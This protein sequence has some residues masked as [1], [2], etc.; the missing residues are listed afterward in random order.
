MFANVAHY[1]AL[2]DHFVAKT[3][4]ETSALLLFYGQYICF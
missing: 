4:S 1:T 3:G 2:Y